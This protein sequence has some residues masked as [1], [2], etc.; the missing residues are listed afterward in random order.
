MF[1]LLKSKFYINVKNKDG[2]NFD[3]IKV[4]GWVFK[5][6][7]HYFG[8]HRYLGKWYTRELTTGWYINDNGYDDRLEAIDCMYK[9]LKRCWFIRRYLKKIVAYSIK[10]ISVYG[11]NDDVIAKFESHE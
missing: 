1:K 11:K 5:K 6:D 4:T 3:T 10:D 2:I 7:G 8:V 9:Q